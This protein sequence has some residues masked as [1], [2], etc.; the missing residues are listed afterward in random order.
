M[1]QASLITPR[2]NFLIGAL[3]FTAAGATLTV[4]IVTVDTAEKR[5][6][7]HLAGVEAAFRDL[8]PTVP[9][10]V[11]GNVLEGEHASYAERLLAGERGAV[12][13]AM[14]FASPGLGR[15]A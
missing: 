7:H 10:A 11:R 1:T 3:G 13:C 8:L 15:E 12:A 6:K 5:L 14:V 4:P 9:A 2:R